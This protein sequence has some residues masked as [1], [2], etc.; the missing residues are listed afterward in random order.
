MSNNQKTALESTVGPLMSEIEA[1]LDSFEN[2]V[3]T[4]EASLISAL[5]ELVAELRFN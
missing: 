2:K 1:Y 5:A 4:H 3:F